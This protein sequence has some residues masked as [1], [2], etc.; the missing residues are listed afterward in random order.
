MKKSIE[1]NQKNR[2]G[3]T[4]YTNKVISIN[5]VFHNLTCHYNF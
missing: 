5:K 4:S 1:N 2:N 3:E